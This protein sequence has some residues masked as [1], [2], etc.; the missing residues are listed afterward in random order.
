MKSLGDAIGE[1]DDEHHEPRA[2]VAALCGKSSM[3]ALLWWRRPLAFLRKDP[4]S[5]VDDL[6]DTFAAGIAET[7]A[8]PS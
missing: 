1:I 2:A 5:A 4:L 3:I 8:P 7:I 6:G